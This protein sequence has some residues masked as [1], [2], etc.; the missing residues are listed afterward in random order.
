VQERTRWALG[1]ATAVARG[2]GL[3]VD[4]PRVLAEGYSV[5]VHVAPSPVVVRVPT[6]AADTRPPVRPWLERELAVTGWL[7]AQGAPVVAPAPGLD[8]GPHEHDGA[9]VSLWE[10]VDV[11]PV[12]VAPAAY[13]RAL[14]DLHA[15]LD[16][17]AGELPV[18]PGPWTDVEVGLAAC[19]ARGLLDADDLALCRRT[20]DR[21]GHLRTAGTRVVHGD[22]HTGN[23]LRTRDG[24]LLWNDWEDVGRGPAE[25]DL[26]SLTLTDEVVAAYPGELDPALLADCR[27]LRRLQVLVGTLGAGFDLPVRDDVLAALRA[28]TGA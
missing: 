14:G 17:Y 3:R 19:E 22:S 23:L 10:L 6:L 2:Q 15:V 9:V 27:D 8:P 24:R 12:P 20:R 13:G 25:W 26:A 1:V 28:A 21:L 7:V 11:D 18:L 16:G 5:R 4:D